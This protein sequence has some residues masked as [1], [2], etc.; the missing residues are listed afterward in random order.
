MRVQSIV[1]LA[2]VAVAVAACGGGGGGSTPVATGISGPTI[3]TPTASPAA[4]ATATAPAGSAATFKVIIPASASGS[5]N[6][7]RAQNIAPGSNS[8]SFQL[9]EAGGVPVTGALQIFAITATSPGC[10]STSGVITC[11]LQVSAPIGTDVFL[12]QTYAS[13]DGSGS[14]LSSGAVQVTIQTNT[15]NSATLSLDGTVASIYLT[16]AATA[17]GKI[18]QTIVPSTR[19]FV[20]ALDNLGNAIL[21]PTTYSSPI[22]L[23]QSFYYGSVPDLTLS[24]VSATTGTT[25]TSVNYGTVTVTSPSDVITATIVNNISNAAPQAYIAGYIG[26]APATP[27]GIPTPIPATVPNLTLSLTPIAGL[28]VNS[29]PWQIVGLNPTYNY[30]SGGTGTY[31]VSAPSCSGIVNVSVQ[32]GD[33]LY[34]VPVAA[35]SCSATLSDSNG[36]PTL[37]LPITVTTTTVTGS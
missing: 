13:T 23:Q 25:S 8:I 22:V 17:L 4:L 24:V 37:T 26:A 18:G 20:I 35:G 19:L 15:S 1:A 36:D 33:D 21:N 11:T 32:Y 16:T 14:L 31:S 34:A 29:N 27:S 3:V 30:I 9:L 10:A 2:V 5:S 6:A 28:A 7:R 12:A